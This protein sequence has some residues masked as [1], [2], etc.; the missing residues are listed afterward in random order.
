[1]IL[2][3]PGLL[4]SSHN[5]WD[6]VNGRDKLPNWERL[7]FDLVQE[8]IQ[9]NT[10]DG[11]TSKSEEEENFVLDGKGNKGKGKKAQRKP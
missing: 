10:R 2:A 7:R 3:L 8:E 9:W 5:Y 11:V 6:S 4:K 1:M